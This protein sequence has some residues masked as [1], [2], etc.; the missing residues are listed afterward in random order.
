MKDDSCQLGWRPELTAD[1]RRRFGDPET[2]GR[3]LRE[4]RT[5]AVVGLSRDPAKPAHYVPAYLQRAGYRI[6]PVTPRPGPFLGEP[7]WGELREVPERA[8]LALVFRP[9][10]LCLPVAEAAIEAGIPRIWF[11]LGIPA[12]AA[13]RRADQ[14]GLTV[15]LDHC[16]MVEHRLRGL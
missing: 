10:P 3:V 16:A 14:A 13:A 12:E 6:M 9:G 11:Q 15:V 1:E 7:T 2:I 5:I 4:T 8:D